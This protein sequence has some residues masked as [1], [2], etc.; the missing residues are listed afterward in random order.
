[1]IDI[2]E[3]H[4]PANET[5]PAARLERLQRAKQCIVYHENIPDREHPQVTCS[6][7]GAPKTNELFVAMTNGRITYV[8]VVKSRLEYPVMADR[9]FGLDVLDHEDAFRLADQMWEKH[10]TALLC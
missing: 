1:V 10:R 2:S 8:E 6:I 4:S 3:S 9:V 7:Y 5:E